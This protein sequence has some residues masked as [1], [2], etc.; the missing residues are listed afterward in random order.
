MEPRENEF[1]V[2]FDGNKINSLCSDSQFGFKTANF[3]VSPGDGHYRVEFTYLGIN[4]I[5]GRP[6]HKFDGKDLIKA[7]QELYRIFM[8][9][10][11]L[12]VLIHGVYEANKISREK[13][14]ESLQEQLRDLLGI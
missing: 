5:I 4:M 7:E 2:D 9:N 3:E 13:G 1:Y 8:A 14:K 12:K 10:C 11:P 6:Q